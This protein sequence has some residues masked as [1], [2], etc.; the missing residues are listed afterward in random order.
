LI[1]KR[2]VTPTAAAVI[3]LGAACVLPFLIHDD[4]YGEVAIPGSGTVHLLPGEIDV[5]VLS[6]RP[7][8]DADEMSVPHVSMHIS[9]PD[10]TPL[11]EVIESRRTKCT[12]AERDI[13]T[14]IW[15]PSVSAGAPAG[16]VG[17]SDDEPTKDP[18]RSR[19][20]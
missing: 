2:V 9:G 18:A 10:G 13:R 20:D 5:T 3:V 16:Y 1:T 7:S 14:R 15:Q 17:R 4:A 11:P 12:T 19:P 8:H 6:A